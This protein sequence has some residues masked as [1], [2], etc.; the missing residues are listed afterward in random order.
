MKNLSIRLKVLLGFFLMLV[1]TTCL[2]FAIVRLASGIVLRGTVRDYLIGMVEENTNKIRYITE[3]EKN[4]DS[5]NG[6]FIAY[7]DGFLEIDKDFL[8]IVNDVSAAL[9]TEDGQML[10]GEN[11]IEKH[12]LDTGFS[13]SRIWYLDVED[14]QYDIYDR[15]LSVEIPNG[16]KLWIRG[17]VSRTN[18]ENQLKE[19]TRVSFF[20]L[21]ILL[22]ILLLIT[23]FVLDRILS[24]LRKI[25]RTAEDISEGYDLKRRIEIGNPNDEVGHL[26]V[27][28]NNML[29]RLE[30][31]FNTERQFTS[32]ASHELRTPTAVIM[33]QSEYTLE[34]ERTVEEYIEAMEVVN[35]QSHRMNELLGDMLDYTRMDQKSDRYEMEKL[36]LSRLVTETADQM[37]MLGEKNIHLTVN[38]APWL[39]VKGNEVLL[40]RMIHNLISNA[41]RYGVPDGTIKV[42]LKKVG[43]C[44]ELSI[45]D[46][47]IGISPEDQEKIFDRFYQADTSRNIQG[48]GLGLSMVKKIVELHQGTI[49]VESEKGKGSSFKVT[50]PLCD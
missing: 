41:F 47:G 3:E 31:A 1:I 49:E 27:I 29:D 12:M 46:D 7:E 24:R 9:Y 20:A 16:K 17:I 35:K 26:A 6:I 38:A 36:D 32:D 50:M 15:Q 44:A 23:Y 10:Y 37:I 34:K 45:V 48:T 28:F 43:E 39:K 25:E 18:S 11:P 8:D 4:A 5:T 2:T 14:E 30:K 40:T 19:I 33:S 42:I 22:I 21:P 13:G